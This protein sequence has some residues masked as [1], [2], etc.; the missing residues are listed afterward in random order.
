MYDLPLLYRNITKPHC[1][2]TTSAHEHRRTLHSQSWGIWLTGRPLPPPLPPPRRLITVIKQQWLMMMTTH[3]RSGCYRIHW[4]RWRLCSDIAS[5]DF[6]RWRWR[7]CVRFW[8][9]QRRSSADHRACV[10]PQTHTFKTKLTNQSKN[11][12]R[13]LSLQQLTFS[14]KNQICLTDPL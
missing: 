10:H 8:T 14:Q 4:R 11:C 12:A 6:P 5:R 7:K 3:G 2:N 9:Y 13:P 1:C